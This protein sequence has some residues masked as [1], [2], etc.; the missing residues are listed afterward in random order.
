MVHKS[1]PA[2]GPPAEFLKKDWKPLAEHNSRWKR[3]WML[4]GRMRGKSTQAGRGQQRPIW[5]PE[6]T[7]QQGLGGEQE[8]EREDEDT[9]W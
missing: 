8:A 1:H 5:L 6:G 7:T 3:R 2:L 9:G 4:K